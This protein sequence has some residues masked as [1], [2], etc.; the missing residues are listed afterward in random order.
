MKTNFQLSLVRKLPKTLLDLSIVQNATI[1]CS[2]TKPTNRKNVKMN[3][4]EIPENTIDIIAQHINE[5]ANRPSSFPIITIEGETET[6]HYYEII[7]FDKIDDTEKKFFA[8]DGSYNSQEF[9][10]GLSVGL[11][12]AG[13]ICYHKGKQLKLNNGNDPI[14]L[15]KGYI[16]NN[17][18]ITNDE[19]KFAIYD[20]LLELEPVKRLIKDCFQESDINKIWGW[21]ENTRDTITKNI[22]SLL[23]FCQEVLEWALVWEIANLRITNKGDFILRD[24][25]LRSNNIKQEYL[26]KLGDFLFNNGIYIVGITKDSPIKLEL[27]STFKKIDNFLQTEKKPKYPFTIKN[28]RWQKLCCWF[29]I[30]DN[31]LLSAYKGSMYAQKGLKGGRGFGL[32]FSARL[33]YVEKLQNYDWVIADL[34]IF[35]CIPKIESGNK[36]RRNLDAIKTIFKELTRLTQEHYILGYPYP[37]VEVHNFVTLKKSFKDEIVKRVKASLYKTQLMDNVDIE[38]LFLDIHDRF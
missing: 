36:S 4:K 20:E 8:I 11:Y 24:G 19:H 32:F 35:D 14:I 31:I 10:N 27:S 26:V 2:I 17:I 16:P 6:P 30:P 5:R 7:Q 12:T 28:P 22:S 25:T 37:L 23:S 9:Y 29:E 13:Y 3:Q 21:G 34:N 18:L 1:A 38:N 33:D 15:G